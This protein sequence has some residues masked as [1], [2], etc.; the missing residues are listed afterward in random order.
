[1][2]FSKRKSKTPARRSLASEF[3]FNKSARTFNS[4]KKKANSTFYLNNTVTCAIADH[5]AKNRI[6]FAT[7]K[8]TTI[9]ITKKLHSSLKKIESVKKLENFE[10]SKDVKRS[11]KILRRMRWKFQVMLLFGRNNF[12]NSSIWTHYTCRHVATILTKTR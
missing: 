9:R 8:K 6:M 2:E 4:S 7:M 11:P 3:E 10:K 1:M 5:S 12:S